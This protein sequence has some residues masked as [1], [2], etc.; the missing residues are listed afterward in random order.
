MSYIRIRIDLA[1]KNP[2]TTAVKNK[3][4]ELRDMVK[5]GKVYATKINEGKPDEENTV[6]AKWHICNHDTGGSCE[7]EQEI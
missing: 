6:S 2:M 1:F 5:Q 3:L 4:D 7:P